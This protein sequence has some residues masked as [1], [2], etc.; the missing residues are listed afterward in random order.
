MA[1]DKDRFLD[2][3]TRLIGD[4]NRTVTILLV[5]GIVWWLTNILPLA[6]ISGFFN[7]QNAALSS[8]AKAAEESCG[9][10]IDRFVADRVAGS[11]SACLAAPDDAATRNRIRQNAGLASA[12]VAR[13]PTLNRRMMKTT[14]DRID[15][16]LNA[17][18][19]RENCSTTV[20]DWRSRFQ[21]KCTADRAALTSQFN[22]QLKSS[23]LEVAGVK[24]DNIP[25]R[26]RAVMM[27]I[28]VICAA[29][30]LA[31][32]RRRVFTFLYL[33]FKETIAPG[34]PGSP[35]TYPAHAHYVAI[36]WWFWPVPRWT[37]GSGHCFR[38][39]LADDDVI[40]RA[41]S[42]SFLVMIGLALLFFTCVVAQ[43]QL[44]SLQLRDTWR[45]LAGVTD[46]YSVTGSE[47]IDLALDGALSA[48]AIACFLLVI[49]PPRQQP[50]GRKPWASRRLFL[51]RGAGTVAVIAVAALA[52]PG[53]FRWRRV[54]RLGS[55]ARHR[56][57]WR[58]DQPRFRSKKMKFAT[59]A[60]PSGWYQHL[61]KPPAAPS[62]P[63]AFRARAVQAPV[64]A[65]AG[66]PV[67]PAPHAPPRG[68]VLIAHF[69]K[70][71]LVFVR[72]AVPKKARARVRKLKAVVV[73]LEQPSAPP[74]RTG[75]KRLSEKETPDARLLA[76][77]RLRAQKEPQK[78]IAIAAGRIRGAGT[79][80]V[81]ALKPLQPENLPKL[82]T[83]GSRINTTCYSEGIEAAAI[84]AWNAGN[85]NAAIAIL[86]VG[87]TYAGLGR[88]PNIRLYDLL[89]GLLVR[90]G[91]TSELTQLGA[92][93]NAL[94]GRS[95]VDSRGDERIKSRQ[96]AWAAADGK[97]Q[98]KWKN[99]THKWNGI[100]MQT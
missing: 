56:L 91:Q 73:S 22:D 19:R 88:R 23:S 57:G 16:L 9:R 42:A 90:S 11:Y 72:N 15:I 76:K 47:I 13:D 25:T 29:A 37:Y 86:R 27:L 17:A 45:Q 64:V 21:S 20:A 33:H 79:L 81:T 68:P 31:L 71:A 98:A 58:Q 34:S 26:F 99:P 59:Y 46:T 94:L 30:L 6:D 28:L 50:A 5:G 92:E 97:W 43:G 2:E 60:G 18:A 40:R 69:V 82:G 49:V 85:K 80:T 63:S 61:S 51:R 83:V 84:D 24:V 52:V 35:P 12:A 36:P 8:R 48:L 78:R 10:T 1:D 54:T 41:R 65:M 77:K 95:R 7:G 70:P 66:A 38:Q 55:S 75:R 3:A 87:V 14:L 74:T 53:V 96:K 89:A 67:A 4:G 62:A 44:S 100:D 32:K 39:L 93:L